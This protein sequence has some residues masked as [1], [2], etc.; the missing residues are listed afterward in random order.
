MKPA[1]SEQEFQNILRRLELALDASQ[2]GV[3]E[4]SAEN[5][6]LWDLQMHRLYATGKTQREVTADHW[7]NAI[8]PDDRA[9]AQEDFEEAIRCK[10]DYSSEFRIVL[11][12]GDIR[13]IRSRAHYYEDGET[14][15]FIGAEWDVTADVMLTRELS[16]QKAIAE[17]RALALEASTAQIEYAAEHDYLTGLPNRRFFDKRFSELSA[18]CSIE[19]LAIL[20]VDLDYFKQ[21]NDTAGHAAGDAVLKSAALMIASVVPENGF[22]A[23]MGGDEFVI[24]IPNF[25]TLGEL[26]IVAQHIVRLLKQGVSYGGSLLQTGASIGVAWTN[27]GNAAGL[28]AESDVALY[29]SKKLGRNRVEFFAPHLKTGLSRDRQIAEHVKVGLERGEFV[30]F[31]QLQVDARTQSIVGIEA[32]AR[33]KHPQRGLLTPESFMKVAATLGLIAEFD[34]AILR[35]IIRDRQSWET[36]G[37]TVPRIAVNTS[38]ARLSDPTLVDQL[39]QLQIEPHTLSFEFLETVFLDEIEEDVLSNIAALKQMEIDIEVDDFG[40]GHASIIGLLKLKPKRLK[41]DQRL[42]TPIIKSREQRSLIRSIV[43]IA[44]TLGIGVIAE[45]V[46]TPAHA[47]LLRRLGCDTLQGYA[48]AHPVSSLDLYAR[49]AA[50]Q[51]DRL[52]G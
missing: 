22:V 18:D 34:A 12:D 51:R 14:A 44:K 35:T 50:A 47:R 30:P 16:V 3:W 17:A 9:R 32:L 4:H 39:K 24:L 31:Y 1:R 2:I 5:E 28:L 25:S 49:L 52:A 26:E 40:S 19:R 36:L 6:V 21:I 7:V 20:H 8:H 38:A 45:G 41:I 37:V 43:D 10:G 15:T 13:H 11:P 23:R 29:R 27:D 46:E 42:V 48:I 33:W